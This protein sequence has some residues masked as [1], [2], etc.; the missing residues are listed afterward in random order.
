MESTNI[1]I[2]KAKIVDPNSPFNQQVV[3]VWI[4][5]DQI[6]KIGKNLKVKADEIIDLKNIHLSPGWFDL[7]A[8]FCDPGHEEREDLESGIHAAIFGGFTAVALSPDTYPSINGKAQIEYVY[9]K[10]EDFPVNVLPMGNISK[11]LEGKELSE[12]Y[13][14]FQAGAVGFSE[15]KNSL[16]NAAL[17]KL[18]LLYGKEFAPAPHIFC[19]ES[20]LAKNGQMHE[21]VTSTTLGL[22]GIPALAEEIS[23]LRNLHLAKYCE[24]PLHIMGVASKEAVKILKQAQKDKITHSADVAWCNLLFTDKTTQN[25][26]ANYKVLPPLRSESDRKAL[27]KAVINGHIKA[28]TSDHS[29]V[30]IENKLCEFEQAQFGMIGLE[31]MF[32]ALGLLR[33]EGLTLEKIIECISI[34]PRNILNLPVASISEGSWAE[35]TLFDPDLEWAF[36]KEHIQSKSKNTPLIG[37]K[38]KGR[39]LGIINKGML[40]LMPT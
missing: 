17:L 29:P 1:L 23:L 14:M 28:I 39:A 9:Q 32:G 13:D 12:M 31:A 37:Q 21:G 18:A 36:E 33:E 4:S 6:V 5:N 16:N 40:V 7:R 20:N 10:A 38:L 24:C 15:A 11:N 3:D 30:D 8:N 26:D 2:K 19:N 27:V 35:L 34:N 22:K 25:Y